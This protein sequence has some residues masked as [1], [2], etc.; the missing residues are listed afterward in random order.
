[1][2][3]ADLG[4]LVQSLRG[5]VG[6]AVFAKA[7]GGGTTVRV[8]TRGANPKTPAQVAV[9][10]NL[11]RGSTL[12][13][14][15]SASQV[16]AWRAYAQTLT[17]TGKKSGRKYTPSAILAFDQLASKF[18]QISPGV[19]VPM[20]PPT[21]SFAGDVI[22][23]AAT[24]GTGQVTLTASAPNAA[25]VK[26]EIL[27]QTLK[28]RNRVPTAKGYRTKLFYAYSTGNL[29]FNMS[30]PAGSYALAYRF[31][32][33]ATGRETALVPINVLTIALSVEDGGLADAPVAAPKRK[34]A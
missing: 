27:V 11:G 19:A 7:K 21:G 12:Y 13:K 1:M 28:S 5:K 30:L 20:V 29:T 16:V 31:V 8:R 33:T 14:N 34:A 17:F 9:R 10:G 2:A 24:S 3:S 18:A 32:E 23:V 26:T 6:N 15:M 22:T 4:I 25:G